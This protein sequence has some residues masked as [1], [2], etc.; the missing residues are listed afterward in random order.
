[1]V[2]EGAKVVLIGA[3]ECGKNAEK[4]IREMGG[5]KTIEIYGTVHW[6]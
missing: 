3:S 5:E 4:M 1:V 2:N 6:R